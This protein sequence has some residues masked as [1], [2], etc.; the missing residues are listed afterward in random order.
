MSEN[1][2]L[3]DNTTRKWPVYVDTPKVGPTQRESSD[4][5]ILWLKAA[6]LAQLEAG[7]EYDFEGWDF[8]LDMY[9]AI[10]GR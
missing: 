7:Y 5:M 8:F 2:L 3:S 1:E 6:H 4:E 9:N 10:S